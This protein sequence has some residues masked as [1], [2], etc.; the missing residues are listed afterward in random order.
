MTAFLARQRIDSRLLR[1]AWPY[2]E[3]VMKKARAL[4]AAVGQEQRGCLVGAVFSVARYRRIREEALAECPF[5][6]TL[7]S[8]AKAQRLPDEGGW[9]L[10]ARIG[11]VDFFKGRTPIKPSPLS[12]S[13][14]QASGRLRSV[15]RG[16]SAGYL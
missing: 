16:A 13:C 15:L 11:G 10:S 14:L 12:C 6:S 8:C 7:E 5:C 3:K 4:F 9:A 2:S 1:P